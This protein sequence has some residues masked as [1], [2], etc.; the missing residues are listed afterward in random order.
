MLLGLTVRT[1]PPPTSRP[2]TFYSIIFTFVL[3]AVVLAIRPLG[4]FGHERC[5]GSGST[6]AAWRAGC[7]WGWRCSHRSS[8]ASTG[9]HA[10]DPDDDPQGIVAASLIFLSADGGMGVRLPRWRSTA[11]RVSRS[12]TS[13]RRAT[14][15]HE[16]RLGPVLGIVVAI[17]IAI[18]VAL[19]FGALASRSYGIYFLMITLVFSVIA[20]LFFGQVTSVSGFGGI[21]RD[22]DPRLLRPHRTPRPP[23]LRHPAGG[24]ACVRQAAV[25]RAHSVRARPSGD[26]RP[27]ADALARLPRH[28]APPARV[29]AGGFR[30]GGGAGFSSSGGTRRSRR[31]PSTP[32][33]RSTC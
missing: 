12:A 21:Q 19:V 5:G 4:L 18:L 24:G 9:R 26:P 16:P 27:G 32:P 1:S 3:L 10:P 14:E 23:L 8:S 20:N 2:T 11:S 30:G 7:S 13:R 31:R 33:R 22:P 6:P 28:A 15:G 29:R 25:R 17:A